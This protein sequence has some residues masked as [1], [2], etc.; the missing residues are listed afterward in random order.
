MAVEIQPKRAEPGGRGPEIVGAR[1][2]WWRRPGVPAGV[3]GAVAGYFL[4]HWLGN[5]LGGDYA[6]SSLADTNDVAIVLGY[7]VG[8]IGW[9]AGLGVFNDLFLM[10]LGK[11]CVRSPGCSGYRSPAWA[12]TSGTRSTT[13]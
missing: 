4:G 9:L 5:F 3:I 11:P 13:R 1:H 7:A 2:P 12:S 6:R 8:V 10:M